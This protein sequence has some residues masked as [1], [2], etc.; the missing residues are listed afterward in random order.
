MVVIQDAAQA[1]GASTPDGRRAPTHGLIGTASFFP[2]K[3]LGCYGDGGACF[4][5]DDHLADRLRSIRVHGKGTDKYDNVRIGQNCRLDTIQA[6]VL[7]E[8]LKIYSEEL[9]QRDQVAAKYAHAMQSLGGMGL[10]TPQIPDGFRS[11]WAQYTIRYPDRNALSTHLKEQDIPSVVYYRTPAHQLAAC[12]GLQDAQLEFPES[13]NAAKTVLSL[14]FHPYLTGDSR[15][16]IVEAIIEFC[17]ENTL[18]VT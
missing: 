1:F 13:E 2:A 8:K 9:E 14:P 18:P 7:I 3:P 5:N 11:A 17:A 10:S 4:T 12:Q 15:D 16:R 6:A